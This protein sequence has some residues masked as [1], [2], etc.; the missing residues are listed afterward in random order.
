[1]TD[2]AEIAGK[3]TK[4]QREAI[5]DARWIHPGGMNPIALVK[6]TDAWPQGIAQFFTMGQDRLTDLGLAVRRYL[7]QSK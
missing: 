1:M 6:F 7:E 2:I 3:L 5:L 4:A